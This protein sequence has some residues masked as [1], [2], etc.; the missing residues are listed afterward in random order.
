NFEGEISDYNTR[1]LTVS[2]D[3]QAATNRFTIT[4]RVRF[5]NAVDPDL[6]YEQNFSRY[7]D[8]DSA[9]SL[10]DVEDSLSRKIVELLVEDIFNRA[11][12]N[13]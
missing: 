9:L 7:E 6:S 5:T 1:P 11:F 13:W 10:A 2:A 3:A 12:V 4:V 8:Y